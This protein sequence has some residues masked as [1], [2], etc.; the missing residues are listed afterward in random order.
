MFIISDHIRNLGTNQPNGTYS[1]SANIFSK[2][3]EQFLELKKTGRLG[4]GRQRV[5][6]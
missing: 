5:K 3:M 4:I 6:Q 2:P 1:I